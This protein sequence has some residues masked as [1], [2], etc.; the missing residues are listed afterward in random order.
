MRYAGMPWGMWLLFAGSF[1]RQ[2]LAVYGYDPET[3]KAIAGKAKAQYKEIIARLPEFEKADRFRMNIVNCAMLSAFL[4]NLPDKPSVEKTTEYY[5]TSMMT[6]PMKWFCRMSGKK[7]FSET[8][9]QGMRAAAALRAAERN[10]YSW[11]MEYLPYP[12]GSG[13]E[14]RFTTCGICTLMRELGLFDLVPAM[15]HLDYTMSEAGGASEFV[16][17]YTLAS[18]GPYCDCGYKK[19]TEIGSKRQ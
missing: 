12:D 3:A 9:G 10:P 14:A 19:K 17:E 8:D 15:C 2:L 1:R 7:K 11:N 13:Y 6:A 4:L 5:R 18:G 16:R